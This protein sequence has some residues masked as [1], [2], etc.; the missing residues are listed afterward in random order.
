M[1]MVYEMHSSRFDEEKL[2]VENGDFVG[3][4]AILKNDYLRPT[5]GNLP[6][7]YVLLA[8]CYRLSLTLI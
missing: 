7:G 2:I 3:V 4:T 1:D 6:A 8:F 5:G